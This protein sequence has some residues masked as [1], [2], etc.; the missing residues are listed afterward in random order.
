MSSVD[1]PTREV[2]AFWLVSATTAAGAADAH[3]RAD[4]PQRSA[5]RRL[6]RRIAAAL[7]AW[8][9]ASVMSEWLAWGVLLEHDAGGC[10]ST[11][12]PRVG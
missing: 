6:P 3:A 10:D 12:E 11:S 9:E 8:A 4:V 7:G 2:T 1:S 5:M